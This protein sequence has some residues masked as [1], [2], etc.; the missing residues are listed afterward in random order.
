MRRFE[1]KGWVTDSPPI[2]AVNENSGNPHYQ[3]AETSYSRIGE[4][5]FLL[6]DLW[7]KPAAP[8]AVYADITWVGFFGKQC[9]RR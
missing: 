5:D 7:A 3:P 2:V 1:E 6:I 8:D 9:R 4:G